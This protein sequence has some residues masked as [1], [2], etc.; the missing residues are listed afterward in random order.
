M[1]VFEKDKV[2]PVLS[3]DEILAADDIQIEL[4]EV[5]EWGGSIF[6]KGMTGAERD[7]FEAGVITISGD[8][9]KVNMIDIRNLSSE[10]GIAVG[11]CHEF[12]SDTYIT[13]SSTMGVRTWFSHRGNCRNCSKFVDCKQ[14]IQNL[15]K[16][17]K[18]PL[19]KNKQ[20]TLQGDFLFKEI[21]R[22][23]KWE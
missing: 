11:Y 21:K 2:M 10:Y 1:S 9:S 16:E 14:V 13:Y 23:L 18:I 12:G 22:R 3:R 6:V 19:P 5:P 17:W 4:L 7:R 8:D 15:S 20:P